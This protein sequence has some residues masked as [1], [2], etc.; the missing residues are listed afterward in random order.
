[1]FPDKTLYYSIK[2]ARY[3]APVKQF[4]SVFHC[5]I[6]IPSNTFSFFNAACIVFYE[7]YLFIIVPC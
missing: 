6:V 5:I 1:M 4:S 2:Y 3:I 7:A